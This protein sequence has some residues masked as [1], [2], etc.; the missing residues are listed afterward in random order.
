VA[1][2]LHLGELFGARSPERLSRMNKHSTRLLAVTIAAAI[3]AA[4]AAAGTAH[5]ATGD[6]QI[7]I[8]PMTSLHAGQTAPFDAAGVKAV[9]R[10]K[11]IPKGYTLVGRTVTVDR[12]TSGTV[13]AAFTLTCPSG[14]KA[15]TIGSTGQN[16]PDVIGNYINHKRASLVV[17]TPP[18]TPKSTGTSY[19]VCK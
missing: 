9:R 19:V 17:W 14:T 18:E 10:G 12:G 2:D 8:G 5:A 11:P 13:G 3:G 15:R 4:G 1:L 6:A 16:G 7:S